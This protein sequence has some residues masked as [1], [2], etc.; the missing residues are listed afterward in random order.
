VVAY[1]RVAR[2]VLKV[3]REHMWRVTTIMMLVGAVVGGGA[4]AASDGGDGGGECG[5]W[6]AE[7]V[8]EAAATEPPSDAWWGAV[9]A[10]ER[11]PVCAHTNT[12][13]DPRWT[14]L[15]DWALDAIAACFAG[16]CE[17]RTACVA[18]A[19]PPESCWA[20]P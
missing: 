19:L 20:L 15:A 6:W 8:E 18:A 17:E 5:A 13:D 4:C 12:C 11:A 3:T 7:G 16:P 9:A 10:C 2:L 14:V 1:L